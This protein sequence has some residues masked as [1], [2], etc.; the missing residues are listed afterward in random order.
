MSCATSWRS[1]TSTRTTPRWKSLR[2]WLDIPIQRPSHAH[3]SGG[4]DPVR[5]IMCLEARRL[6]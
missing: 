2:V 1:T 4:R 6:L 5:A 3:S